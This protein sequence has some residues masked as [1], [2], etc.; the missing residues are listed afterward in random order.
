VVFLVLDRFVFLFGK[1]F[2]LWCRALVG[3]AKFKIDFID[4]AT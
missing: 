1:W 2:F 3:A 4:M